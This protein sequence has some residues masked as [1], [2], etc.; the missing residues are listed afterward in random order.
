MIPVEVTSAMLLNVGN[1]FVV[2]LK[3]SVDE[4]ALPISIGQSEAQS[5]AIKL[6]EISF[7][8]PMTHDLFK[9]TL[10][11]LGCPLEKVEVCDLVDDTFYAR[12]VI[13]DH[14]KQVAIDARPSDAVSLAIRFAVPIFVEDKVMDQAGVTFASTAKGN[15]KEPEAPVNPP[16][17]SSLEELQKQL[18]KAVK[19]ERY[20]DAARLR[21]EINK[22]AAHN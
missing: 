11:K 21:D 13:N 12:L 19:E 1:E 17:R 10:E 22:I 3:S 20:E 2:L 4:R 7:P 14:G 6:N 15:K 8:R 5:I 16:Q 9:N 18:K